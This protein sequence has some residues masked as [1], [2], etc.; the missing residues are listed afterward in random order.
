MRYVAGFFAQAC[1]DDIT[2]DTIHITKYKME[3]KGG[4]LLWEARAGFELRCGPPKRQGLVSPG[5]PQNTVLGGHSSS[6]RRATCIPS[7]ETPSH[8]PMLDLPSPPTGSAL[9][10]VGQ[11]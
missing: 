4:A 6:K 10:R 3:A 1:R 11:R 5:R 9:S 2:E 7:R 8:R